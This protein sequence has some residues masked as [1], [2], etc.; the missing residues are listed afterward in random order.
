MSA[1]HHAFSPPNHPQAIEPRFKVNDTV[2]IRGQTEARVTA[3]VPIRHQPSNILCH[4]YVVALQT[5]DYSSIQ[6]S[7]LEL[8]P[9][10]IIFKKN[11]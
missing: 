4:H 7:Q 6:I 9:K 11:R 1:R 3:Y 5:H 2:W 8:S 10:E